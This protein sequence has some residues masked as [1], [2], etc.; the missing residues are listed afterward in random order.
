M[1]L[2]WQLLLV[3]VCCAHSIGS[4]GRWLARQKQRL[5]KDAVWQPRSMK[6]T[7]GMQYV[8]WLFSVYSVVDMPSHCHAL[9]ALGAA[10]HDSCLGQVSHP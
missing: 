1:L 10:V 3:R 9:V 7:A 8:N 6:R 5:Q 4:P 2:S